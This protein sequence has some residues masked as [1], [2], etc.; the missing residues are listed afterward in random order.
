MIHKPLEILTKM[1]REKT[2]LR[3]KKREITTKN[4][5]IQGIT[6]DY[7]ETLYYNKLENLEEMD[8]FPDT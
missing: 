3:N 1:R 7:F 2:L 5:E 6:T 8:K 4:K